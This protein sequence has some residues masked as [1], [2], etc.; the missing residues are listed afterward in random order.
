MQSLP[1]AVRALRNA[2]PAPSVLLPLAA[3]EKKRAGR[4]HDAA[5][6]VAVRRQ[7]STHRA[8]LRL[9]W[10]IRVWNAISMVM[11]S[12]RYP[13]GSCRESRRDQALPNAL[14]LCRLSGLCPTPLMET[15]SPR[16]DPG[17]QATTSDG[18]PYAGTQMRPTPCSRI[19]VAPAGSAS[20]FR[21]RPRGGRFDGSANR[22]IRMPQTEVCSS[23]H[24]RVPVSPRDQS[25]GNSA[26]NVLAISM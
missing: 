20:R 14:R 18:S 5:R 23:S 22:F 17:R 9:R 4:P 21:R 13:V 3:C 7:F 12:A 24:S 19:R 10:T 6:W 8:T 15:T 26:A 1:M 25:H 11:R 2:A 16:A